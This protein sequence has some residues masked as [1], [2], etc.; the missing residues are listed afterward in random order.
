[1]VLKIPGKSNLTGMERGK[2]RF[3]GMKKAIRIQ[4]AV[5]LYHV[6]SSML[7]APRAE[8]K[9][10]KTETLEMF[11]FFKGRENMSMLER[12]GLLDRMQEN[13]SLSFEG[14]GKKKKTTQSED[15]KLT[16]VR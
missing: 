1:M 7:H 9:F 3:E 6:V 10:K 5:T 2:A 8:V 12:E 16:G 15:E 13:M 4:G 14:D 11:L